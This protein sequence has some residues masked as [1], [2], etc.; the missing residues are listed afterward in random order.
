M[1][2]CSAFEKLQTLAAKSLPNRMNKRPCQVLVMDVGPC[3]MEGKMKD[4]RPDLRACVPRI[5]LTDYRFKYFRSRRAHAVGDEESGND[6]R[7]ATD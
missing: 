6:G 2:G 4:T 1:H 3:E 7:N 5:M